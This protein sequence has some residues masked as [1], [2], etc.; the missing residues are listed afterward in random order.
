MILG[1]ILIRKNIFILSL[2]CLVFSI[3]GCSHQ[4]A[5]KSKQANNSKSNENRHLLQETHD[6]SFNFKDQSVMLNSGYVMPIIGLGTY[7]LL[8]DEAVN[9]VEYALSN[10]YRK[11][12]TAKIYGN[13]TEIGEGIRKSGIPREEIFVTTKL[14]MNQ[15]DNAAAA[16]DRALEA[17]DLDYIDM[18]LLHHPGDHD[19]DAYKAMEK[20]VDEG[21]LRSIGLSN[22]YIEELDDFLSKV[23]ITP[24]LIQNEVHPYYQENEVIDYFKSKGIVMEG[25][26]P[27][28]GR[29]HTKE[30]FEDKTISSIA[31]THDRSSA[32]IILR[33]HLQKGVVVIPGSS[34]PNH[35][36]ENLN[37]FDFELSD[38]EMNE[39]NALNRNQKHDWY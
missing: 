26:Y 9:S 6:I 18:M 30:L 10:G 14:Y 21:K 25:W 39:I 37:I 24:A 35:I 34:N 3:S 19:V 22:Y 38:D 31:K 17:F 13:E 4:Q 20:A 36:S 1:G 15:Y 8:D 29:G 23:T 2:L 33:W 16:I 32:Q 28:G 7:S 12:D 27:L 11:I 5:D